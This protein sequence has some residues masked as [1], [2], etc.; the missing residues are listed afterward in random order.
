MMNEMARTAKQL[1]AEIQRQ[2]IARGLSQ[3]ALADLVG[4]GQKT[5]S[6][7]ENGSPGTRIETIFALLAALDMEM[8]LA[9]RSAGAR[10][11]VGDVF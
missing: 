2:R 11:S 10:K 8:S 7:I 3:L 4:T 1:G 6:T 9:P 5:V